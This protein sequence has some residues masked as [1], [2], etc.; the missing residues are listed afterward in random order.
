MPS[1]FFF[2][3]TFNTPL[4]I[5]P[6]VFHNIAL[7][8]VK[9]IWDR[10]HL[11]GLNVERMKEDSI[12]VKLTKELKVEKTNLNKRVFRGCEWWNFL[13]YYSVPLSVQNGANEYFIRFWFLLVNVVAKLNRK[14]TPLKVSEIMELHRSLLQFVSICGNFNSIFFTSKMHSLIHTVLFV[15]RFGMFWNFSAKCFESAL[16]PAKKT[17]K[18]SKVSPFTCI[19]NGILSWV[20]VNLYS[21]LD[22]EMMVA[23]GIEK[24]MAELFS[25]Y[26]DKERKDIVE[27]KGKA[28]VILRLNGQRR[29]IH[30]IQKKKHENGQM[31]SID[32]YSRTKTTN[33]QFVIIKIREQEYICKV[34]AIE[35]DSNLVYFQR[36][37]NQVTNGMDLSEITYGMITCL[38][39]QTVV[40]IA[41]WVQLKE[42]VVC[43]QTKGKYFATKII[44]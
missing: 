24:L 17:A 18:E 6:E 3:P 40:E 2:L 33:N 22:V 38:K 8:V 35:R 44:F 31:I 16:H 39:F 25:K 21:H 30:S 29:T 23:L 41:K 7:G 20:S 19:R 12:F 9:Y 11:F 5:V 42:K 4:I 14:Q 28:K 43:F 10:L 34:L 32:N 15:L 13:L 37:I 36:G 27:R 26:S 1:F